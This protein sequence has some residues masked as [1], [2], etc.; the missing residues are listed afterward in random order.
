M[1]TFDG[2]H[3]DLSTLAEHHPG[4]SH[5]ITE[6][7]GH[8]ITYM[9]QTGHHW[10]KSQAIRRLRP[11]KHN[12]SSIGAS[13]TISPIMSWDQSLSSIQRSLKL[14]G[15]D[16]IH[17]KTTP[18]GVCYY[19]T[20]GL[21][22][23]F[24]WWWWLVGPSYFVSCFLGCLAWCWA[25]FVQHEGSHGSLSKHQWINWI[26]RYAIV[27]WAHPGTWYIRHVVK[28]H[29][30][31]NTRLDMDIQTQAYL[32]VRH[33]QDVSWNIMHLFQVLTISIG[34]FLLSFGF[35]P[36]SYV[37]IVQALLI[38]IHYTVYGSLLL[39]LLP[40]LIFGCLFSFFT[41]LNHIQSHC[42]PSRLQDYPKDFVN[43]QIQSS[44]DYAHD[45]RLLSCLSMFL[46]YQTYHHLFP[47]MSHFQLMC[48]KKTIDQVL[49][50][51]RLFVHTRSFRSVV[52]TY[53]TYLYQLGSR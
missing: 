7:I 40:F 35:S 46:N 11:Y 53:Y 18:I 6:S 23:L 27:P 34:G 41:Q 44:V 45:S 16:V 12:P 17:D 29:Q 1:W 19:V 43:H 21:V 22:Y 24:T 28:H 15:I 36:V 52:G 37:P 32:P 5:M 26:A 13:S 33:H 2:N 4:G 42:F 14:Y 48:H 47:L 49:Q 3:Y 9:V 8:D 31:T 10:N 30:F 39:S 50:N 25:G 20:M 38:Y 51:H